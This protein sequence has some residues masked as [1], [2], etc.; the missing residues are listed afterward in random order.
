MP[1]PF[2]RAYHLTFGT[3]GARLHGDPRGTIDRRM[4]KPGDTIVGQNEQ[5]EAM[6]RRLLKHP[7]IYL[8]DEQRR[9]AEQRLP[10]VC[11]RGGWELHIVGCQRD[12]VHVLVSADVDGKAVRRWLKAWLGRELSARWPIGRTWWAEGGS[13]RWVWT[14]AYF[15][16]VY[17]YIE[18]QRASGAT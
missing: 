17:R 2:P 11:E 3:Y 13:V 18:P 10:D 1:T 9:Y 4:N 16:T 14:D 15:E 8:T 5:W 7:P 6:E 12:H